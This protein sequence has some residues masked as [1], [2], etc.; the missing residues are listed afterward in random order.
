MRYTEDD[1]RHDKSTRNWSDEPYTD[2]VEPQGEALILELQ[3]LRQALDGERR[4]GRQPPGPPGRGEARKRPAPG[5]PQQQTRGPR[6]KKS[7]VELA[8][9]LCL[10]PFGIKAP[11]QAEVGNSPHVE[12]VLAPAY[13]ESPPLFPRDPILMDLDRPGPGMPVREIR[14]DPELA[15]AKLLLLPLAARL[16]STRRLQS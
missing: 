2:S 8:I 11:V 6:R 1:R 7:R 3:R 15:R 4:N 16:R 9:D 14:A 12:P 5:K 13:R 10:K